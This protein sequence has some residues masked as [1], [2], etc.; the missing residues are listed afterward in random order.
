VRRVTV[1]RVINEN[2]YR[3]GEVT[4]KDNGTIEFPENEDIWLGMS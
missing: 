1:A 3:S 4:Y 2:T